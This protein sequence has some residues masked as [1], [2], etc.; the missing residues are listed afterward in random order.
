MGRISSK[1]MRK[2]IKEQGP[3]KLSPS[4]KAKL[5][6]GVENMMAKGVKDRGRKNKSTMVKKCGIVFKVKL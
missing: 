5:I 6:K 3:K 1:K 2:L 4:K